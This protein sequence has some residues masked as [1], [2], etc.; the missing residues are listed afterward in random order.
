STASLDCKRA[1]PRASEK[2][3]RSQDRQ[4]QVDRRKSRSPVPGCP[5]SHNLPAAP[6]TSFPECDPPRLRSLSSNSPGLLA[7]RFSGRITILTSSTSHTTSADCGPSG[8]P[9]TRLLLEVQLKWKRGSG[10]NGPISL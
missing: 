1:S 8:R 9:G 7:R 5:R 10:C 3:A 2:H 4:D 6:E